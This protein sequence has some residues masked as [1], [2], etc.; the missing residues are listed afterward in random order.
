[1][2]FILLQFP[3]GKVYTVEQIKKKWDQAGLYARN[4]GTWMHSNIESYINKLPAN[5][6]FVE[7]KYFLNYYQDHIVN[8]EVTPY[9]T[10]WS[11]ASEKYKIGGTIDFVGKLPNGNYILM[12]WK[13]SKGLMDNLTSKFNQRA[14]YVAKAQFEFFRLRTFLCFLCYTICYIMFATCVK[15]TIVPASNISV[16]PVGCP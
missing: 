6:E 12:D 5:F 7:M 14:L 16:L 4:R 10:E 15:A 2:W 13:R 11:I 9:R 8:A 3:D 1:M